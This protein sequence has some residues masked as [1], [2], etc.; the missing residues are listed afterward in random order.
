MTKLRYTSPGVGF[1]DTRYLK[2]DQSTPQ[3][4]TGGIPKLDAET[5]DFDN[6][7]QIV[8]KRYV[9]Q[10][11]TALGARYYMLDDA[12]GEADY[13][14][15]STSPSAG[16]E[17]SVSKASLSNN[18]Y[19]QGWI[20][21]SV[22]QPDK[23]LLGVYNW[24]IYAEKTGGTKTLRLYWQLV[25]RAADDSETILA[26]SVVS[27]EIVSGKNSYIIPLTLS[28]DHD[29]ASDSYVVGKIYADVS[30]G[31]NAPS[32]TLYH[33]G[34][35]D[36]HWE[37]PVNLEILNDQFVNITGDTMT[38]S[39]GIGG[40]LKIAELS[41]DPSDPDEGNFVLW[42]S[43]GTE[44]GDDGDVMWMAQAGGVV[45][46]GTLVDFSSGVADG[47]PMGL[48]LTLTYVH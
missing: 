19:I 2:L 31:G 3:T 43:D 7:D 23:L 30:G 11:V 26:T 29:I 35:S 8:N 15:C 21:P 16:A 48:L 37:I 17:Q 47:M 1:L 10:A 46:Y 42:M 28:A 4:I 27:N 9:D 38:G 6:L 34:N 22:N 39:L 24:R 20:S 33:E 18:D 41:A 14:L 13:K 12:S 40:H 32:V 45:K 36:S 5:S 44:L 25:E